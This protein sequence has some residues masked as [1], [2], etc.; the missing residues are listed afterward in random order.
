[1]MPPLCPEVRPN[2]STT[3][4]IRS[5]KPSQ[6]HPVQGRPFQFRTF[7]SFPV[8]LLKIADVLEPQEHKPAIQSK[9]RYPCDLGHDEA[10]KYS[11]SPPPPQKKVDGPAGEAE[12]RMNEIAEVAQLPPGT[13]PLPHSVVSIRIY[14]VSVA[15]PDGN[16]PS[17]FLD[18]LDPSTLPP[19]FKREGSDW[20]AVFNPKAKQVLDVSLVHTLV[21]ERL[22]VLLHRPHL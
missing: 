1:M 16:A 13:S 11:Q 2:R 4:N 20:F 17:L 21:H 6:I 9:V 15:G 14:L 3:L 22:A 18:D 8:W 19:E 7:K 12:M 10:I 5:S